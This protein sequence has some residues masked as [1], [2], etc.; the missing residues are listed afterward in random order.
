MTAQLDS[1]SVTTQIAATTTA[2]RQ[3]QK[4]LA[5]APRATKDAALAAMADAIDANRAAILEA[6][7][8]DL[9]RGK[10]NHTAEAL[11]DRL[12]LTDD[13]IDGLIS[14]L[15]DL[16]ALPDPIGNVVR[17]NNLPNG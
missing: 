14:A 15:G 4:Q 9:Q 8:T 5:G 16:A 13:R 12:E 11:L 10:E 17:G 7:A 1:D 6:N 2:A 3:A